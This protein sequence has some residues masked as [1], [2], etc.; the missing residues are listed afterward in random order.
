VRLPLDGSKGELGVHRAEQFARHEKRHAV[1]DK[2]EEE[3][4]QLI[5]RDGVRILPAFAGEI[6]STA[7]KSF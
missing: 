2:T 6:G 4:G 1:E 7:D 5:L 3:R